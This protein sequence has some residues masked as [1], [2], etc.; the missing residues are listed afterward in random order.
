[1]RHGV[2]Q[3]PILGEVSRLAAMAS[4]CAAEQREFWE[5][6]DQMERKGI[7]EAPH[8]VVTSHSPNTCPVVTSATWRKA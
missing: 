7:D 8:V 6:H 1:M 5:Y 3:L 2:I 4:E